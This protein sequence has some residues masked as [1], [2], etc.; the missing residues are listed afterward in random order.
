MVFPLLAGRTPP[1][2]QIARTRERELQKR[3]FAKKADIVKIVL[4]CRRELDFE[5]LKGHFCGTFS[6]RDKKR[7]F[8]RGAFFA[9]FLPSRLF[10]ANMPLPRGILERKI[11]LPEPR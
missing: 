1:V 5:G 2:R 6:A 11:A 9:F 7:N 8:P 3:V 10:D 4:P